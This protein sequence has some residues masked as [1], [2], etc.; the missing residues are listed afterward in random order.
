MQVPVR[1]CFFETINAAGVLQVPMVIS[2]W[3]DDYGISVH[4][5]HQTTKENISE[6]LKGF[7]RDKNDKG[8]D[9]LKVKGW[10]YSALVATYQKAERIAREEH[11]PVMIHVTDLTQPQGHSTSGSHE[12]YKSTDRFDWEKEYDCLAQMKLWMIANHIATE[13]ELDAI[14]KDIKKEVRLGKKAAWN[15]FLQPILDEKIE[16]IALINDAAETSANRVFITKIINDLVDNNEPGRKDV[17]S[18]CRRTLRY[19]VGN[20][21]DEKRRLQDWINAYFETV[22]PKYSSH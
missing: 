12:R 5:K 6:I 2:V 16:A 4:A 21:S 7:Q 9:I 14:H 11:V 15:A 8:Y 1:G 19:L 10:D 13:E 18:A 3:D 20:N 17:I 22:Q